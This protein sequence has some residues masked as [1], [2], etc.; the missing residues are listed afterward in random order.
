LPSK[1]THATVTLR[2]GQR[3]AVCASS[4]LPPS[5]DIP[6]WV[7]EIYHAKCKPKDIFLQVYFLQSLVQE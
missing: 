1:S 2:P 6:P 4:L 5:P 7:L 3:F